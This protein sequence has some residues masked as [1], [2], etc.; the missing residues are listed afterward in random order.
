MNLN[1]MRMEKQSEILPLFPARLFLIGKLKP[2][3]KVVYKL[4][5]ISSHS[6]L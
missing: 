5:E 6:P 3:H 2:L 4:D 1:E